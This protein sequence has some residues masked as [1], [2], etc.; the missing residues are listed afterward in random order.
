VGYLREAG[1][2]AETAEVNFEELSHILTLRYYPKGASDL[3]KLTWQDFT[4]YPGIENAIEPLIEGVTRSAINSMKPKSVG[5]AISGGVDSTTVTALTRKLFPDLKIKTLCV[6]FGEDVKE[7]VDAQNVA[8]VF[9]TDHRQVPIDN[10]LQ[11]L[12]EMI[13]ITKKPRWN[14]YTYY[15]FRDIRPVDVLLTGDGG[16]EL[17]GGYVFRYQQI[18]KEKTISPQTYL[19][20]HKM[21]WVPDQPEMFSDKVK[22]S[23]EK[24]YSSISGHF[25]NPLSR[26]GQVFLADYSGKLLYDFGPTNGAFTEYFKLP[27]V[28]PMLSKEVIYMASHLPYSLKYDH[29][30]NVGKIALRQIL[31]KNFAYKAAVKSKT[32]FG[33]DRFEMWNKSKDMITN[34][35]DKSR[36]VELGVIRRE[37]LTKTLGR[38]DTLEQEIKLRYVTK[39]FMILALEVWLRLFVTHEMKPQDK[40]R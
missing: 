32:G 38:I 24:I 40:L 7:A 25:Q 5:V 10:P 35:L 20:T 37:W 11:D 15:F 18:L 6:T 9:G 27:T 17:F 39:V 4:E 29:K 13:S 12:P 30:N 23:W 36:S 2:K 28:A 19:G 22:F 16:D 1:K 31:M 21:D 33:M 14:A 34:L 8:E 26:L 3:P